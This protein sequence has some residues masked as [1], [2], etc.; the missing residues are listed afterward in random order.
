[1]W[2]WFLPYWPLWTSEM[3]LSSHKA[4]GPP[5]SYRQYFQNSST[6]RITLSTPLPPPPLPKLDFVRDR[7]LLLKTAKIAQKIERVIK[8]VK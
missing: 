1:M 2:I 5:L 6:V 3:N 4:P 8:I 7:R